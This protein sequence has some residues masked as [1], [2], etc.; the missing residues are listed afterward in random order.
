MGNS[1]NRCM[2]EVQGKLKE[3]HRCN[4]LLGKSKLRGEI[5]SRRYMGM[6]KKV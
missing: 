1:K 4:E 3:L 6:G 5:I 2:Q